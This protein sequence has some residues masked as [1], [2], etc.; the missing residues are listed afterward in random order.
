MGFKAYVKLCDPY[1]VIVLSEQVGFKE[2]GGG[3][4]GAQGS[5]VLSEQVGFKVYWSNVM[6]RSDASFI[7]TS[8]I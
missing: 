4:K 7:R 3:G 2:N 8:G 5:S 6:S 1:S